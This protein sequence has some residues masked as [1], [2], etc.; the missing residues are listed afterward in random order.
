[1]LKYLRNTM[2]IQF[3]FFKMLSIVF[4]IDLVSGK[5]KP[6]IKRTSRPQPK[7]RFKLKN[8]VNYWDSDTYAYGLHRVCTAHSLGTVWVYCTCYESNK[9]HAF[10]PVVL[11]PLVAHHYVEVFGHCCVALHG[12]FWPSRKHVRS[13]LEGPRAALITSGNP[14]IE[15]LGSFCVKLSARSLLFNFPAMPTF[16]VTIEPERNFISAQHFERFGITIRAR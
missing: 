4:P 1:M 12:L 15:T 7:Q 16:S 6:S 8:M 2:Q 11:V 3:I 10:Q 13:L 14:S 5:L 9:L